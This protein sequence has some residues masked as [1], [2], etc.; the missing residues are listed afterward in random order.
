M[1]FDLAIKHKNM[2]IK[3]LEEMLDNAKKDL[4]KLEKER[5]KLRAS[6]IDKCEDKTYGRD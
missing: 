4:R 1:D 2:E 6:Q 5:N 3:S